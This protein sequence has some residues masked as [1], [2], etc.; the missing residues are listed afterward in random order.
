MSRSGRG[1]DQDREAS[2]GRLRTERGSALAVALVLVFSFTSLGVIVLARDYDQRVATRSTAQAIAFQAARAG[3]Q[4]VAVGSLRDGGVVRLDT[5]AA[6]R[7]AEQTARELLADAGEE[8][9]AQVI[10][11]GDQVT[12]TIEIVDTISNGFADSRSG[13]VTAE[14]SARAVSG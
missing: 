6:R 14:G 2:G 3:A 9:S 10:V 7:E 5:E 8:G 13:R 11:S 1:G 4:Q 12:V